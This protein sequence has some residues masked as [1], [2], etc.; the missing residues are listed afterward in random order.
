ME[1]PKLQ[2]Q[3]PKHKSFLLLADGYI[4]TTAVE[5]D[6]DSLKV[7]KTS[8]GALASRALEDDQEV[9]DDVAEQD[10]VSSHSQS[11]SGGMFPPPPPDD[12][13]YDGIE[14]EDAD[15]GFPSP[16]KQLDVGDEVYDDVD[17][18]DFPAPP[19]ELSQGAKA[20]TEEKDLKKLKKQEKEEKDF[21][22]KFKYDGEIRVLYS[23]KVAPALTSKRWGTRDLQVKPGESLE[24]IQSTDDTK[25]LC[26]N[27]EGKYGYVLRSYLV[28]NDGEIYDDIADGC[29][30]D[31]D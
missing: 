9:Y 29:I 20:K 5:I 8:L 27:E 26:R 4:R 30:Y 31:N 16:P 28:D 17:A 25:V 21:R 24:V 6:Y 7:K 13:I 10:D 3:L 18:S 12:D 23:T 15:D 1:I 14:E 11:G 19:A 2:L 22:K